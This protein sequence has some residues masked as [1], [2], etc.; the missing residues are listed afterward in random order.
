MYKIRKTQKLYI[1]NGG[2]LKKQIESIHPW[3][4]EKDIE[5]RLIELEELRAKITQS[6]A[7]N[8]IKCFGKSLRV[9]KNHNSYAY[10]IRR[11]GKD[12]K[13]I[14]LSKKNQ[15]LAKMLAV[16]EYNTKLLDEVDTEIEAL[17][18]MRK[19][20]QDEGIQMVYTKLPHGKQILFDP[21]IL[22]DEKYISAWKSKSYSGRKF[23]TENEDYI[24]ANGERVRSKSEVIL[25]DTLTRFGIPY[26]YEFPVNV[27]LNNGEKMEMYPDFCCLNVRTRQEFFWEH[28]G[29]MDNPEYAEVAV[30][31][32]FVYRKNGFFEG[33]NILYTYETGNIPLSTKAI[34]QLI[35]KY[36][37]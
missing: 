18:K 25:A 5:E 30:N 17:K 22:P 16:R 6:Q 23:Q 19:M 28:F 36:L 13:G 3:Y 33:E 24:T 27:S 21:M 37:I 35:K 34:E 4:I 31:K 7:E 11:T 2:Q 12:S 8:E 14:Y 26:R 15:D 1:K 10:Y 20:W 29:M 32:V 9:V